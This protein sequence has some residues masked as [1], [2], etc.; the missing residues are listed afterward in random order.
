MTSSASPFS[1]PTNLESGHERVRAYW[2]GLRRGENAIPFSD[3][4]KPA[5]LGEL[6]NDALVLDVFEDP[7]RFRLALVGKHLEAAYG[8][9]MNGKFLDELDLRPPFDKLPAQ[10]RTAVESRIP[11]YFR[12]DAYR[13]SR[14]VLPLW[15][16]GRV[17]MLLAAVVANPS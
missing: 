5:S 10:C 6:A 12:S 3:D 1:V 13:Y 4:V 7:W 11:T 2:A 14:L 17:N 9:P 16:E 8:H 15:G